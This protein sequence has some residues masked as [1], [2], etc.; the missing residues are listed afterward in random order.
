[1]TEW[2]YENRKSKTVAVMSVAILMALVLTVLRYMTG[3]ETVKGVLLA[4]FLAGGLGYG[5]H[6]LAGICGARYADV[7]GMVSQMLP[8]SAKEERP[9]ACIYTAKP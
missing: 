9:M 2:L 8:A 7:F 4:A 6:T 5:W 3:Y 1:M